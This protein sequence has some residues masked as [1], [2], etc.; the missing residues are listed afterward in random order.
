MRK[1]LILFALVCGLAANAQ[2]SIGP[3]LGLN[4]S[5]F[6][7]SA[8]TF[9]SRTGARLGFS[10]DV[11]IVDN[12]FLQPGLFYSSKGG[13]TVNETSQNLA[14][15][16]GLSGLGSILDSL[17]GG[18]GQLATVNATESITYSI[19]YLHLPILAVYKFKAGDN[20]NFFVGVGPYI[21]WM[22]DGNY[23]RSQ[24]STVVGQNITTNENRAVEKDTEINAID[25]GLNANL[26]YMHNSGFFCRAFY[27]MGITDNNIGNNM[28]IGLSMGYY[29]N[30]GK[31]GR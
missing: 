11:K 3:E 5:S 18:L 27:E 28:S 20:G 31:E 1:L 10:A 6:T 29:F 24:V 23:K 30:S 19:N 13:H 8:N 21:S 14:S 9:T 26:G 2:V 15:L 16:G 22:M 7:G 12:L 4:I 25:F 17:G